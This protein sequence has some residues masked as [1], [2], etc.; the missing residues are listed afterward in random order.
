M[1]V[2]E[3]GCMSATEGK[4]MTGTMHLLRDRTVVT[5]ADNNRTIWPLC[6]AEPGVYLMGVG[7]VDCPEC[8][9]ILKD[10]ENK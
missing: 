1:G 3:R 9:R 2:R 10:K 4:A 8:L 7:E 5:H 6:G